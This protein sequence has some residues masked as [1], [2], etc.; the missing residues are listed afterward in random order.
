M[1]VV[2]KI[3]R[4]LGLN[5]KKKKKK[6]PAL[7][8][9]GGKRK[10][11]LL[12]ILLALLIGLAMFLGSDMLAGFDWGSGGD[13]GE[14]GDDGNNTSTTTTTTP[15]PDTPSGVFYL[16]MT[17]VWVPHSWTG[18]DL[19]FT[20][21]DVSDRSTL[22]SG[23]W[24]LTEDGQSYTFTFPLES[25]DGVEVAFATVNLGLVGLY[26]QWNGFDVSSIGETLVAT[27]G[28]TSYNTHMVFSTWGPTYEN[29]VDIGIEFI[30]S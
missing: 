22:F 8:L 3:K 14:G 26:V 13:G 25:G 15:P 1:A 21:T 30:Y 9:F 18:V 11:Y 5:S 27:V 24:Y 19:P 17:V 4:K 7:A 10:Q 29:A 23:T 28:H 12:V 6:K 2:K 16:R 20:L